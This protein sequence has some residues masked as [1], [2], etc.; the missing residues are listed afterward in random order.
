VLPGTGAASA[1]KRPSATP[2]DPQREGV[3]PYASRTN[4]GALLRYGFNRTIDSTT[5]R[6]HCSIWPTFLC[7]VLQHRVANDHRP[8]R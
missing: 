1:K 7:N 6:R 2:A 4:F 3:Y 5:I 8:D